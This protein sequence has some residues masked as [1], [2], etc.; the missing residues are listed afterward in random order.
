MVLVMKFFSKYEFSKKKVVKVCPH[1]GAITG[2]SE[3]KDDSFCHFEN[4][5]DVPLCLHHNA[6]TFSRKTPQSD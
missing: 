2:V 6:L 3:F 4:F 1:I 5:G